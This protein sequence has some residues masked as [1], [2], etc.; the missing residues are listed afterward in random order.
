MSQIHGSEYN[1]DDDADVDTDADTDADADVHDNNNDDDEDYD[2][3]FFV[4]K[5]TNDTDCV[6]DVLFSVL[7]GVG[8]QKSKYKIQIIVFATIRASVVVIFSLQPVLLERNS[9]VTMIAIAIAISKSTIYGTRKDV[10]F[11]NQAINNLFLLKYY[12][13]SSRGFLKVNR[14]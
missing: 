4:F 3:I 8:C 1:D 12:I 9:H 7:L 5:V 13:G 10:L 14:P 11:I 6:Y 2:A